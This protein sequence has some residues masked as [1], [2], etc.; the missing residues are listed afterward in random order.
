QSAYEL[1]ITPSNVVAAVTNTGFRLASLKVAEKG[2]A[3]NLVELDE[4]SMHDLSADTARRTMEVAGVNLAGGHLEVKRARDETFNLVQIAS[5][6]PEAT[7]APGGILMLMRAATN[8][9]ALLLKSAD[10]WSATVHRVDVTNCSLRWEDLVNTRPVQVRVEDVALE[11][12]HL[13]N[14]PGSNETAVLSLKWNT[15]GT[16]R[17]AATMQI[18]PAS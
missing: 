3:D 17:I 9:F 11:A 1:T 14:V 16:V 15:N 12:R 2:S 8:A 6:P 7:N 18:A 4:F 13:S 5:P 10:L